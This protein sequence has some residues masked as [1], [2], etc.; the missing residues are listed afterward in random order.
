MLNAAAIPDHL[1]LIETDAPWC[2]IKKTHP[3]YQYITSTFETV[4]K[5]KYKSGFMIKDRNE[6][7][8]LIQ[9]LEV[10]S[11]IRNCHM[12][13]LAEQIY[14]NTEKLFPSIK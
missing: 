1:L 2:G 5:E 13:D 8:T 9:I 10:L 14:S 12:I 4:K 7:C 11:K 3:S 6:P